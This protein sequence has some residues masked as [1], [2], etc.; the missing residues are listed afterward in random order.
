MNIL[1]VLPDVAT[2]SNATVNIDDPTAGDLLPLDSETEAVVQYPAAQQL[3]SDFQSQVI[4][5]LDALV[6][7][8]TYMMTFLLFVV[9]VLLIRCVYKF[10]R[11]FI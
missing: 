6:G 7:L 11:I 10:I 3:D 8:G 5:R 9:V 4:S 2:G 1:V